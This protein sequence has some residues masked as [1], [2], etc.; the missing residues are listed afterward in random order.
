[1]SLPVLSIE[2]EGE[3]NYGSLNISDY[4][5]R[6]VPSVWGVEK[7]GHSTHTLHLAT[8]TGALTCGLDQAVSPG[9]G[10]HVELDK[11]VGPQFITPLA[12][13]CHTNTP[14]Q[15]IN[16]TLPGDH[17][18]RT[19]TNSHGSI[20][21]ALLPP[22]ARNHLKTHQE[23]PV[24]KEPG[25]HVKRE[26]GS[27]S[28]TSDTSTSPESSSP[29]Y[30]SSSSDEQTA[31]ADSCP[32]KRVDQESLCKASEF[33][34]K[35]T[36]QLIA[37]GERFIVL[38]QER[39]ASLTLDLEYSPYQPQCVVRHDPLTSAKPKS[40]REHRESATMPHKTSKAATGKGRS[41]HKEKS[42]GHHSTMHPSKK[43]ENVHPKS[44]NSSV[45]ADESCEDGAV[46]VIETIVITEKVTPKAHGKKKKKHHQAA[47]T[48]KAEAVPLAE[49]ENGAKQKTAIDK[50]INVEPSMHMDS[51]AKQKPMGKTD[52]LEARL[53]QRN[54]KGSDKSVVHIKNDTLISDVSAAARLLEDSAGKA[55]S[56]KS[57]NLRPVTRD[58]HGVLPIESKLQKLKCNFESRNEGNVA[59]KKAYSEVVKE[60]K[61][62]PKQGTEDC[63][64]HF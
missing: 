29:V 48:G 36:K 64:T 10:S 60:K 13:I 41:R 62:A 23:P 55:D 46:T 20:I 30:A 7:E 34:K 37:T 19:Y 21:A 11:S 58:K 50:I 53:A 22:Y 33:S 2:E 32:E 49:V 31:A 47:A 63:I 40:E 43:Q 54:N 15:L 38:E 52:T 51:G 25:E 39:V 14:Q 12:P 24:V 26:L 28:D 61:V 44:Q 1:M 5:S 45:L 57:D 9:C 16:C 27:S 35:C 6:A 8:D 18:G 3:R 56:K 42:G 59:H 4:S 17:L